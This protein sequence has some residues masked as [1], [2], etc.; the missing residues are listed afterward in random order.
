MAK[1]RIGLIVM[2][3]L[4]LLGVMSTWVAAQTGG[5]RLDWWTLDAGGGASAAGRFA[6]TGSIGQPDAGAVMTGGAYRLTGGYWGEAG[7][8]KIF[9]P[10]V[11]RQQFN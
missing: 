6:V 5:Y 3:A 9:L 2:L 10:L 8:Y 1:A 7:E 4:L 11:L